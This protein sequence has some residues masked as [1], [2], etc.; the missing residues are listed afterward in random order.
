MID[1]RIAPDSAAAV[2]GEPA[3]SISLSWN[4]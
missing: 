3:S 1:P 2:A 4:L